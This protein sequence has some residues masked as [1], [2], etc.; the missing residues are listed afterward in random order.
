MGGLISRFYIQEFM[1]NPLP[2]DA[3]PVVSHLV[4]LGTPNEGSPCA[5]AALV[6]LMVGRQAVH[7]SVSAGNPNINQPLRELAP[8]YLNIFNQQITNMRSV[9]FSVLAGDALSASCTGVGPTDGVV[10]VPSAIWILH[11]WKLEPLNHLQMTGSVTAFNTWVE[12]HLAAGPT[13]AGGG[14][15]TGSLSSHQASIRRTSA[16]RAAARR[17]AARRGA[18][19]NPRRTATP[20]K[21][22]LRR[23][24]VAA[25]STSTDVTLSGGHSSSLPIAVPA[26]R[27]LDHDHDPRRHDR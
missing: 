3:R 11:D 7:Q 25:V 5:W 8:D 9:P 17:A 20:A 4:M 18:S 16:R 2:G 12:P 19:R 14:D 1:P 6:A 23:T 15:Y 13:A 24:P 26:A 21:V 27:W 22:C 10:A